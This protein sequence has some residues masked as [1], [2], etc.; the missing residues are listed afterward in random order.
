MYKEEI[1]L[2]ITVFFRNLFN[3]KSNQKLLNTQKTRYH[4][5]VSRKEIVKII[6][7]IYGK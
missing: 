5:L 3:K 7:Y 6:R 4:E 1:D 2:K